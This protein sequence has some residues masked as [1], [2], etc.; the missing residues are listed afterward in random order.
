[1]ITNTPSIRSMRIRTIKPQYWNHPVLGT[2]DSFT[3][4]LGIAILNLADDEG[5]FIGEAF[6]VRGQLFPYEKGLHKV[7]KGLK[8]LEEKGYIALQDAPS[9]GMIGLVV[10]FKK[11]QKVNRPLPSTLKEY[12]QSSIHGGLSES[13]LPEWKGVGKE[14][15]ENGKEAERN[16]TYCKGKEVKSDGDGNMNGNYHLPPSFAQWMEYAAKMHWEANSA[17]T[18]YCRLEADKWQNLEG[19]S[20]MLDWMKAANQCAT[21]TF[22]W[23]TNPITESDDVPF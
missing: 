12:F 6:F 23:K 19:S 14:L 1:M 5:Y 16:G 13:S 21:R 8:L 20:V 9:F 15:E 17:S 2:L 4:L 22:K 7:A 11:H 3:K 18:A 10:N